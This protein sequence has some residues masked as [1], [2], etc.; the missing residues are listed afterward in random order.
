MIT[1]VPRAIA[2]PASS[3]RRNAARVMPIIG[4]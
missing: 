2:C 3:V 1:I 4:G